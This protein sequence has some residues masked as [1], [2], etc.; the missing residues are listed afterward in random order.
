MEAYKPAKNF[1]AVLDVWDIAGLVK[2][3]HEGKGL[4]NEFLSNIASVDAIFHL[5][6]AFKD[7]K[8]DHVE[9]DVNPIRDM[10]IIRA[11]LIA[12]DLAMMSTKFEN[13]DKAAKR[14]NDK[15]VKDELVVVERI[16]QGLKENK[17]IQFIQ[18]SPREIEYLR[19]YNLFTAKP[20]VFLVN[21]G[22]KDWLKGSN[23]WIA[24][25]QEWVKGNYPGSPVIPFS[26]TFEKMVIDMKEEERNKYLEENKTKSAINRIIT[27][28]YDAL[29]LIHY[30]TA[31]EDEVK[32]WTIRAG[33]K[34]PQAAGVIHTDFETGFIC[35]EVMSYK[36]WK[37]CGGE[38]GCKA[39]GKYRQHGKDYV[40]QDGDIMFFKFNRP[41]PKKK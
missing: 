24:E 19:S 36:D 14:S 26:A 11:E 7:K 9:G 1:R 12:K 37:K 22:L 35:A 21:V 3:A 28:G 4:G 34:A 29:S 23:K 41:V 13:M 15:K 17:E 10:E 25:I 33:T 30:F 6:R 18:W 39:T 8:I 5:V 38:Q 27:N 2:G 31:G 40:V 20:V 32:C 16:F